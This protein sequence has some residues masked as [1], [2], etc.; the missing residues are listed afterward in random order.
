MKLT[1]FSFLI[2]KLVPCLSLILAC[3]TCIKQFTVCVASSSVQGVK[4][5]DTTDN[6]ATGGKCYIMRHAFSEVKN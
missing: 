6:M 3:V 5:Y 1:S 2:H 4:A